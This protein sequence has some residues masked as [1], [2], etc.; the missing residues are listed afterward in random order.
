MISIKN[1]CQ[2]KYLNNQT[3]INESINVVS[4][5]LFKMD[6][7]Y[8]NFEMYIGG[9]ENMIKKYSQYFKDFYIMLFID[10]SIINNREIFNRINN[11]QYNKLILIYYKCPEFMI[12]DKHIELFGLFIRFLPIFDYPENRTKI[13]AILDTDTTTLDIKQFSKNYQL[14]KKFNTEYHCKATLFYDKPWNAKNFFPLISIR[15][16]F[17]RKFPLYLFTNF[18]I[19]MKNKTCPEMDIITKVLDYQKYHTFPYGFDEY[20]LNNVLL[21]HI[22]NNNIVF[23]VKVKYIITAPFYYLAN[24]INDISI[25]NKNY[26]TK[27]LQYIL[28]EYHDSNIMNLISKFDKIFFLNVYKKGK[29]LDSDIKKIA[30]RFYE[31]IFEMWKREQ[32]NL[33]NKYMLKII[34]LHRNYI[35]KHYINIYEGKR[36]LKRYV[37]KNKTIRFR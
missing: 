36:L 16:I 17:K 21:S 30:I 24:K 37:I 5:S 7:G 32:Y 22:I 10:D 2:L 9:F 27:K 26:L 28:N 6:K 4:M 8:K 3:I 25:D 14:I 29:K 23:S 35:S 12:S 11:I 31:A 13:V 33:F 15:Q 19:C 18:L 34:L 1:L 20:F